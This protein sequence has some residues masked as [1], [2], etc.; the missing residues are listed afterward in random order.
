MQESDNSCSQIS[1]HLIEETRFVPPDVVEQKAMIFWILAISLF[2]F[3]SILFVAIFCI[4]RFNHVTSY[5]A[6]KSDPD[7]VVDSV[8]EE[9]FSS[10]MRL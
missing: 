9:I 10:R 5:Q 4:R 7:A 2:V 8:D 6:L 3:G 1:D